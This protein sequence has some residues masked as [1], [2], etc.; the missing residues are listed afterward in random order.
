MTY[1]D[2]GISQTISSGAT[3]FEIFADVHN[4][5]DKQPPVFPGNLIAGLIYPTY[6]PLYDVVGRYM[7][8]GVR[9]RR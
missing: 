9:L 1:F 4:L 5:F 2:A 7:T 3:D 8:V 6:L